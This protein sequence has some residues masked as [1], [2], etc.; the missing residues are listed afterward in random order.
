MAL[1]P[2]SGAHIL[3]QWIPLDV[4]TR[5]AIFV[6]PAYAQSQFASICRTAAY[7]MYQARRPHVTSVSQSFCLRAFSIPSSIV[8]KVIMVH[9][10]PPLGKSLVLFV[11]ESANGSGIDLAWLAKGKLLTVALGL[12]AVPASSVSNICFS[13]DGKSVAFLVTLAHGGVNTGD[14]DPLRRLR[15]WRDCR[16]SG[17]G[18]DFFPCE[19]CTVQVVDLKTDHVGAPT[20]LTVNTFSHVFV[21]EYGFDMVW[22][23]DTIEHQELVFAAMLHSEAGAATYLVRWRNLRDA[24]ISNFVFMACIDG[25][26][27]ELLRDRRHAVM[28]HASTI[29]TSRIELSNDARHIFFDTISKFGIL[30]FDQ[31]DNAAAARVTRADLPNSPVTHV[32]TPSE[33]PTLVPRFR[34]VLARDARLSAHCSH[35][36]PRKSF[37][38]KSVPDV[39]YPKHLNS[40]FRISRMSPDGRLLCSVIDVQPTTSCSYLGHIRAKQ[41][42]MRS[43][44]TGRL[45]YRQV[46]NR[47][48]DPNIK[49]SLRLALEK[50]GD[51]AHHT[52]SFSNDSSLL[53]LWDTMH[54]ATEC[55]VFRNLPIVLDARSGGLVQDFGRL[56]LTTR[57][58]T[59]QISPDARTIYATKMEDDYIKMDA[60]DVL[61]ESILKTVNITGPVHPPEKFSP[62]SVY[63]LPNRLLHTVSRGHVDALFDTTRGSLGC[64]W[65]H[66]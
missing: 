59:T 50:S 32:F 36:S 6:K 55:L 14:D 31:V 46:V 43:S 66:I 18:V 35:S 41:V 17:G 52:I 3:H 42:E 54:T 62:H 24:T 33:G 4:W 1:P 25:A 7:A 63:L 49:E 29:Y 47:K 23:G 58:E 64:G 27:V 38:P 48:C 56:S 28:T 39:L 11:D 5:I 61:S 8:D 65:R 9:V 34:A 19:D 12:D 37:S 26:S 16:G 60:I 40:K 2:P 13:P 10:V 22:R 44:L 57:Y 30:R 21:P 20:E 51:T 53:V 15:G 45:L